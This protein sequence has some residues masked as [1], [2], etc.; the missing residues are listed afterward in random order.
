MRR[1]LRRWKWASCALLP[2]VS[3]CV[4]SHSRAA[5]GEIATTAATPSVTDA[6]TATL[7]GDLRAGT[8]YS[9][10]PVLV[11]GLT[12]T[13]AVTFDGATRAILRLTIGGDPVTA[14]DALSFQGRSVTFS[15]ESPGEEPCLTQDVGTYI[16]DVTA[17]GITL[18]VVRD[19]CATRKQM[20]AHPLHRLG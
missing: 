5:P 12:R 7:P 10:G 19:T 3:A 20:F 14:Y 1:T 15:H 6:A 8:P 11:D 18:R 17:T 4:S 16:Y 2:V 13:Y 9:Y